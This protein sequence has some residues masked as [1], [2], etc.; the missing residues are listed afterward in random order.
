MHNQP[1]GV[2]NENLLRDQTQRRR[3]KYLPRRIEYV[4]YDSKSHQGWLQAIKRLSVYR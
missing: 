1:N 2:E 4:R 3:M